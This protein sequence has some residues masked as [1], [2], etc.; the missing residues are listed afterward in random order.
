MSEHPFA[1]YVRLLGK[2]PN[3]SRPLT[4]DETR[5]AVAMILRGEV[6][7]E[8]L[9]AFLCLLRVKTETPEEVAGFALAV[10]DSLSVPTDMPR[11]DLDWPSYAGKARQL[12]LFILAALLLAQNGVRVAMH[13]TDNHTAGRLYTR[14]ALSALGFTAAGSLSEAAEQLTASHFTYVPMEVLNP[15]LL[16]IMRLKALLG[17]RSPLHTVARNMNPFDAKASLMSVFHPNYRAVHRDASLLMGMTRIA[18]FKGDGGEI[19]RRPEKPC[20]VQ[21]LLDGVAFE[22]EWPPLLA[23]GPGLEQV[24][25]PTRLGELWRGEVTDSYAETTIAA[26]AA[27]ALRLLGRADSPAQAETLAKRL[28]SER[29]RDYLAA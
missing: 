3:L 24:M 27:I 13:G 18:C 6:E 15:R 4:L 17:L 2:G 14:A 7:P 19:E 21:G 28:W 26:T 10:R 22:E 29:R 12:P 5:A 9:G 25:D 20:V 1:Q 8:Q 16:E 23:A 11:V